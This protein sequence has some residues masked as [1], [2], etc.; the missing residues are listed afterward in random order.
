MRVWIEYCII[1]LLYMPQSRQPFT[2]GTGYWESRLSGFCSGDVPTR[3]AHSC[4]RVV[5]AVVNSMWRSNVALTACCDWCYVLCRPC[6]Q[7]S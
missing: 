3:I 1:A 4:T 6:V 7:K 5:G 2:L